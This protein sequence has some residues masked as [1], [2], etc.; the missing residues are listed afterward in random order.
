MHGLVRFS[1][2][3]IFY[4]CVYH[5]SDYVLVCGKPSSKLCLRVNHVPNYVL[6]CGILLLF[7]EIKMQ[8][9]KKKVF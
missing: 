8:K 2:F 9:N 5:G 4:I 6:V 3:A 1:F 7:N